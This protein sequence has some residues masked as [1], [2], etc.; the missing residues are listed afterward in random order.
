MKYRSRS[1]ERNPSTH[2]RKQKST[3][4]NIFDGF[5]ITKLLFRRAENQAIFC[6]VIPNNSVAFAVF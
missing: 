3:E 4:K 5:F 6:K 1:R 2:S